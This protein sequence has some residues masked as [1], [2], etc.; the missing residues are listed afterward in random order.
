MAAEAQESG[1][2]AGSDT[3]GMIRY[4]LFP[5]VNPFTSDQPLR[6]IL[7]FDMRRLIREKNRNEYQDAVLYFLESD[8]DTSLHSLRIRARGHFRKA[9]CR[10]PPIKLNFQQTGQQAAYLNDV[11]K[12]KLVTHCHQSRTYQQYLLKEFMIYRMYNLLTDNSFRVR[13]LIIEYRDS[14]GKMKSMENYGFIIESNTLLSNRLNSVMVERL[15]IPTWETDHYQTNLMA[16]F[17]Y[18]IGNPDWAIPKLQNI[19]LVKSIENQGKPLAI[20]YDFDYC[21]MVNAHYAIPHEDLEIQSVRTRIY[22]GY[23]LP[24][25][26]E[27]QLYF[28]EFLEI[29]NNM[30]ALVQ[31]S[32]LLEEKHREEMIRYLDSFYEILDDPR[33]ARRKIIEACKQLPSR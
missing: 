11:N 15:N 10:F 1:R 20:P 13:L 26:K 29:K 6:L 25:E 7:E 3:S 5:D 24:E 12:L 18:M 28:N 8:G 17:Q 23:C 21:G 22:M 9:H 19:R 27:Y 2:S 16:L 14:E 32:T 4:T 30:Y 33:Q 31:G